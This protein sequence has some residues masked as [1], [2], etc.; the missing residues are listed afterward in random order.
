MLERFREFRSRCGRKNRKKENQR[1]KEV[2]QLQGVFDDVMVRDS[3]INYK[4]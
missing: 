3:M 1:L 2:R 4:S